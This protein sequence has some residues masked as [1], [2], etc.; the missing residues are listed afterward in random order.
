MGKSLVI[1][2]SPAKARTINKFLGSDYIVKPTGGHVIDLPEGDFGID[3]DDGFKPKYTVIKGKSK[4]LQDLKKTAKQVDSVL[5][6]TDPDREGEAIAWHVAQKVVGKDQPS[7]RVLFNQITKDA[8]RNAVRDKG[9]LDINKVNA[10]QARRILDRLVGYKV[11]PVL[12]KTIYK[13]LSAGRVQSVALRL[14]VE[15]DKDIEAFVPEEYWK[16]HALLATGK[17]EVFEAALV[18]KDGEAVS[19]GSAKEAEAVVTEL[20]GSS[21]SVGDVTK[22]KTKRNPTPPFITSTL[23]QAAARKLG[24]SVSRTMRVA[25]SLYEGIELKE[26][27][28]GLITYMRTD[29]TRIAPE[30]IED[31]R[32]YITESWGAENLPAKPNLYRAK[33]GAQDAHEAI[34]PASLSLPPDSVK[35]YLTRDQLRLYGLIWNK[36]VAS[37]MKP[38][39]YT[40]ITVD[41]VAGPYGLRATASHLDYKGYLAVY[42]ESKP[43]NGDEVTPPDIL[44]PLKKEDP[45]ELK[46]T[47][48]SQHFTKPPARFT[49]AS[50]VK[51]LESL[52]I[53][54]PSTYAQII[55]TILTRKYVE[56]EKGRL[57]ATELGTNVNT[58]LVKSFPNVFS[59]DFTAN[60]EEEL[61]KV[62]SGAFEWA[63]VVGDFYTPFSDS[64]EKIMDRRQELKESM[65][66]ET[67]ESCE[68]CGKPMV[69]RWGRNGKFLACSGFPDCRNTRP[70]ES[71]EPEKV[72]AVCEKCGSP[73][74]VK[75]GRYGRF[76]ACSNYPDCKNVKPYTLGVACPMEGCDGEIVEKRSRRGKVFF[77]CSKYPECKYASWTRPVSVTCPACGCPTVAEAKNG[78]T[79]TC[80]RCKHV[81]D[82]ED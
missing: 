45:L 38:A 13:G 56:R 44:P 54:R 74:E 71:S 43:E 14:I 30:A 18:K 26:G 21:F 51:E 39:E 80:P 48:P 27:S 59:V 40:N 10:Q 7:F 1:V 49:E 37:Q 79:Y 68:K 47:T 9:E 65:I 66:E 55:N 63:S 29:S 64:L 78:E 61:D 20:S 17:D 31:V 35:Q 12:W 52:G 58:I 33:K 75:T 73:M 4:V 23:Q 53:G 32:N 15:R 69:I 28:T 19:I 8:V 6:A 82:K 50:L 41:I 67:G 22:K 16:I 81:F 36:F 70:L 72:D 60:M 25:Q 57:T 5:L 76:L 77:G 3:V 62:E 42:E 2:E 46:E 24:F 34:R 11:S